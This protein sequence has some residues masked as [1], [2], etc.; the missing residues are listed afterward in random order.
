MHIYRSFSFKKA[1]DSNS[2]KFSKEAFDDFSACSSSGSKHKITTSQHRNTAGIISRPKHEIRTSLEIEEAENKQNPPPPY[3]VLPSQPFIQSIPSTKPSVVRP[4]QTLSPD[5]ME[6]K[7]DQPTTQDH[8][9]SPRMSC[10]STL[11]EE[12]SSTVTNTEVNVRSEVQEESKTA[13]SLKKVESILANGST[14][15]CLLES[16]PCSKR[17]ESHKPPPTPVT[18]STSSD[19]RNPMRRPSLKDLKLIPNIDEHRGDGEDERKYEHE[20]LN[21]TP[22]IGSHRT[23]DHFVSDVEDWLSKLSPKELQSKFEEQSLA[24]KIDQE[25]LRQRFEAHYRARE[26]AEQNIES[27]LDRIKGELRSLTESNSVELSALP[28]ISKLSRCIEILEKSIGRLSSLSEVYGAVYQELRSSQTVLMAVKHVDNLK[29]EMEKNHNKLLDAKKTLKENNLWDDE[30]AGATEPPLPTRMNSFHSRLK[31]SRR[32]ASLAAVPRSFKPNQSFAEIWR[33]EPFARHPPKLII[34]GKTMSNSGDKNH[35]DESP[36]IPFKRGISLPSRSE[37]A[38]YKKRSK[39]Q[40]ASKL[41]AFRERLTS[42]SKNIDSS[43]AGVGLILFASTILIVVLALL[44]LK[45]FFT[46]E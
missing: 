27:E 1:I 3:K 44:S 34:G 31:E 45:Y 38:P 21:S 30:S 22:F 37:P 42:I 8:D 16:T 32:R 33:E 10:L 18:I 24:L 36:E 23:D 15:T 4:S 5:K 41:E 6:M 17:K 39:P 40:E 13:A 20:N 19:K 25:S 26:V 7:L 43:D 2:N 46:V 12:D 14:K 9:G 11:A 35:Y 29:Q 28:E